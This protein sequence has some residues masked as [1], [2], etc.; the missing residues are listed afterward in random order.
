MT[1][2]SFAKFSQTPRLLREMTVD[3]A[4]C[5]LNHSQQP[6]QLLFVFGCPKAARHIFP[7]K[8]RIPRNIGTSGSSSR[9][10]QDLRQT[11]RIFSAA[12]RLRGWTQNVGVFG[13]N[14]RNVDKIRVRSCNNMYH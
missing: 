12:F 9:S 10:S 5:D 11:C 1:K 4:Q 8:Q 6:N 7:Q 2:G 14:C 13:W 3:I